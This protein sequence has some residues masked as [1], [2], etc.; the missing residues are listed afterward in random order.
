[1]RVK[2]IIFDGYKNLLVETNMLA[3]RKGEFL[4]KPLYIYLGVI[5]RILYKGYEPH[6]K[7]VVLGSSGIARVIEDQY[8]VNENLSGKIVIVKPYGREGLLGIDRDGLLSTYT[9][10]PRNYVYGFMNSIYPYEV[11]R[12]YISYA[13]NISKEL[14]GSVLII[15][16]ELPAILTALYLSKIRREEP[17]IICSGSPRIVKSF[18]LKVFKNIGDLA[19]RY[20]SIVVDYDKPS[21]INNVLEHI[22][23]NKI[24]ITIFSRLRYLPTYPGR[25]IIVEYYT[26]FKDYEEDVN[27]YKELLNIVK[28]HIRVIKI[29]DL[30]KILEIIPPRR[31]G[32]IVEL[33]I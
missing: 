11:L 24:V 33:N 2:K 29:D 30:E 10:I 14:Y 6:I 26:S 31:L 7:P 28:K 1:M 9:S 18:G 13:I 20:N 17:I 15:G 3:S 5:E 19:I 27:S 12:P 16:C 8:S 23:Y 32:T 21:L 25:H 22:E 4:A